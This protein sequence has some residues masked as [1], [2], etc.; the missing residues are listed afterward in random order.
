VRGLSKSVFSALDYRIS[1]T[2]AG[3]LILLLTNMLPAFGLFSCNPTGILSRLNTFSTFLVYAYRAKHL[4][5]ETPWWYAI[6]HPIGICVFIY[7]M[8]RSAST[9]VINREIEWR[10]TRYPLGGLKE[11]AI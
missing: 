11:N 2:V 8:L 5:D 6:L 1:A 4:G 3:V 9:T 7:A 10:K